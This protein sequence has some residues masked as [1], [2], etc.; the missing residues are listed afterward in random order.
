MAASVAFV[1]ERQRN[2]VAVARF[3]RFAFEGRRG[4][5]ETRTVC[6]CADIPGFYARILTFAGRV[7]AAADAPGARR[8]APSTPAGKWWARRDS[9]PRQHRYE[10]RVLTN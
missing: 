7:T 2:G 4:I 1:A 3:R 6:R 10:R 8:N 5:V 9:N